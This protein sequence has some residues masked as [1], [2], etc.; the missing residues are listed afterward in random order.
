MCYQRFDHFYTPVSCTSDHYFLHTANR[1]NTLAHRFSHVIIL[2]TIYPTVPDMSKSDV[3]S[4]WP[5]FMIALIYNL[6]ENTAI[7][8]SRSRR[9]WKFHRRRRMQIKTRVDTRNKVTLPNHSRKG[10]RATTS[11]YWRF[12]PHSPTF[13]ET[14]T[15]SKILFPE[16][17]FRKLIFV[18]FY[19]L[20]S[21]SAI[22]SF[23]PVPPLVGYPPSPF[24]KVTIIFDLRKKFVRAELFHVALYCVVFNFP[25]ILTLP[26]KRTSTPPS[27]L[28]V[29]EKS[30]WFELCKNYVVFSFPSFSLFLRN[31]YSTCPS[32]P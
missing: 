3:K 17:N 31:K 32:S 2:A 11:Q 22:F 4:S 21:E 27:F 16:L 20:C 26:E 15:S 6:E 13:W 29:E 30:V 5:R 14:N 8:I 9:H 23:A 25:S 12:Y 28:M 10:S 7:L 24:H 18:E 19:K 1:W